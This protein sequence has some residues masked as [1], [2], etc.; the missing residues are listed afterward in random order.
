M[1]LNQPNDFLECPVPE[2]TREHV[3]VIDVDPDFFVYLR[4]VDRL[5]ISIERKIDQS[6]EDGACA[7]S[8]L[9]KPEE[10]L[11]HDGEVYDIRH[12]ASQYAWAAGKAAF[13]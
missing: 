9:H 1:K 6:P 10:A 4:P 7:P 12:K 5:E 13:Q 2:S 8:A 11:H 3:R